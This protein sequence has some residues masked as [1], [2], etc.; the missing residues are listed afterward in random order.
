[1][2]N[3]PD[4]LDARAKVAQAPVDPA[5]LGHLRH[6]NPG[7]LA[8]SDVLD[9]ERLDVGQVGF[10]GEAAVE[11]DLARRLAVQS[12][13]SLDHLDRERRVGRVAFFDDHIRHETG[14]T[15]RQADLVAVQRFASVLDDDV[16]MRLEDGDQLLGGRHRLSAEHATL[17]LGDD[18][19]GEIAVVAEL[20]SDRS[21][22]HERHHVPYLQLVELTGDAFRAAEHLLR[23]LEKVSVAAE[24]VHLLHQERPAEPALR[25]RRCAP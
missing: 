23:H 15:R 6:R 4:A 10:R 7:A 11:A 17:R 20:L 2:R 13:L 18:A 3:E 12:A 14:C 5:R 9:T 21:G 8:E 24:V 25:S 16:R 19:P 1:L 22:P